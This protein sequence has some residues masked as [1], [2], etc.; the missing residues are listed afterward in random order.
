MRRCLLVLAAVFALGP[1]PAAAQEAVTIFAAASLTEGL[2]ALARHWESQGH[3]LPRLSFAASSALARQIAQGAPADL[4]LSAD[5]PWMDDVQRRGLIVEATRVNPLGNALVLVAP[6]GHSRRLDLGP[7]SDLLA[8]L[9]LRGRLAVGDP[10]HVP[11]GRY[12]RAALQS[13]GLWD[14]VAQRL[15]PAENVRAALLLVERGEAPLGIVYA[16]DAR[17][18]PGMEVVGVFPAASHPPVTYPF[19][20]TRRAAANP[21]AR[22][23]LEF[24][25]GPEA[26]ATWEGFGF[27]TPR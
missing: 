21:Q 1:R 20:L 25:A 2:R 9:G 8:L 17:A 6:A 5:E 11:V 12:A 15:A 3:P 24:L 23:L 26:R 19:A 10:A 27:T 4:F 22:A 18:A 14:S 16:T 13:L 7:G